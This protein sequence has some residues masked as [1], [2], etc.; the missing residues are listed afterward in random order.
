MQ[1]RKESY[2][3]QQQKFQKGYI[4]EWDVLQA[5]Q[6]L[7]D[8]TA[9]IAFY[10][11][12]SA[13]AEHFL[14]TLMALPPGAVKRGLENSA[15]PQPPIIPSGLPSSLLENRPDVKQAEYVYMR[16]TE[17]IGVYQALRYPSLQLTGLFGFASTDLSGL[18][19]TGAG[20]VTE[21]ILGPIFAA[22]ANK[23]RVEAQR[24]T[25]EIAAYQYCNVNLKALKEVEDALVSVETLTRELTARNNR[26]ESARKVVVLSQAR[27]DNGFSSYLE[28]LDAQRTLFEAELVASAVRQQQLSAYVELYRSLGG[29]W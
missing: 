27:Y 28:L 3:L 26:V 22:G 13:V 21:S 24:K 4:A 15:E 17:R 29:G 6:L 8:A 16:E 25:A 19:S 18:F 20:S 14:C 10:E 5:K 2:D 9:T 23:R 12:A 7:D 1:T 11:R